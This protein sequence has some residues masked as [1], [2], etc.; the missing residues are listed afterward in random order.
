[1]GF[2]VPAAIPA[3]L[4]CPDLSVATLMGDAGFRMMACEMATAQ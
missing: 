2:A 3:K 1:M 4:C